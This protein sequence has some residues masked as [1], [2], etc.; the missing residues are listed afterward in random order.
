[1]HTY[2]HHYTLSGAINST[3]KKTTFKLPTQGLAWSFVNGR[4]SYNSTGGPTSTLPLGCLNT[5]YYSVTSGYVS[6]KSAMHV[7]CPGS[8]PSYNLS[9]P[10]AHV[11]Y[12]G[13]IEACVGNSTFPG[14]TIQTGIT[15]I[16]SLPRELEEIIPAKSGWRCF[17]GRTWAK[18][19]Y[20]S[21]TCSTN[22]ITHG[23]LR[24]VDQVSFY[25]GKLTHSAVNAMYYVPVG[26]CTAERTILRINPNGTY[27]T[28]NYAD[29]GCLTLTSTT[30]LERLGECKVNPTNSSVYEVGCFGFYNY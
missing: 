22:L 17:N 21:N 5:T 10:I 28:E 3:N 14:L 9:S 15:N 18:M 20:L 16:G 23:G 6:E 19:R 4:A 12:Y 24:R 7:I 1:M 27:H 13:G 8:D 25:F 2:M 29:E 26:M 11:S 30:P